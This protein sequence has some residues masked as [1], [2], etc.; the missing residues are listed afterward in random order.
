M[1]F[2][3]Q[4][5]TRLESAHSSS[6][7]QP[8]LV[9]SLPVALCRSGAEAIKVPQTDANPSIRL[10]PMYWNN[11]VFNGQERGR[12]PMGC[13]MNRIMVCRLNFVMTFSLKYYLSF[14]SEMSALMWVTQLRA[15]L[16]AKF[17]FE[18]NWLMVILITVSIS[19][20]LD[21]NNRY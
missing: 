10:W 21:L 1:G 11:L 4:L 8:V 18:S 17:Y 20:I 9:R 14:P 13:A 7:C 2:P 15:D 19:K 3:A 5:Q 16:Q 12:K 6:L